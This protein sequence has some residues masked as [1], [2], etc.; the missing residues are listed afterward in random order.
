MPQVSLFL[1]WMFN[2][3]PPTLKTLSAS[4]VERPAGEWVGQNLHALHPEQLQDAPHGSNANQKRRIHRYFAG[5]RPTSS[6]QDF[7]RDHLL[8]VWRKWPLCQ[9]MSQGIL[10]K[11]CMMAFHYDLQGHLA[12]LSNNQS[13]W[14]WTIL[15]GRPYPH[16]WARRQHYHPVSTFIIIIHSSHIYLCQHAAPVIIC[17]HAFAIVEWYASELFR[18]WFITKCLSKWTGRGGL[19]F[20]LEICCRNP[21]LVLKC[22]TI[23]QYIRSITHHKMC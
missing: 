10:R 23:N 4:G 11:S 17:Y 2:F 12:F 15:C 20:S 13:K 18:Q 14:I 8:Q 6:F 1:S 19:D 22:R 5:R 7:G 16:L 9:Q 3:S 21:T